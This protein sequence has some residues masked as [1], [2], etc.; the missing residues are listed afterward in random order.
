METVV[1]VPFASGNTDRIIARL[2]GC[3]P[4]AKPLALLPTWT[5]IGPIG[6]SDGG[7]VTSTTTQAFSP[8]RFLSSSA[9][10][11][12]FSREPQTY[13]QRRAVLGSGAR[14]NLPRSTPC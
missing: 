4:K 5:M 1:A 10:A 14:G 8:V 11:W 12:A 9:K 7:A 6:P 13:N 2:E 3:T